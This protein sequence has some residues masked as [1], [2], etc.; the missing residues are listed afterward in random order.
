[1][2]WRIGI[3]AFWLGRLVNRQAV[4]HGCSAACCCADSLILFAFSFVQ[5]E[6]VAVHP[7]SLLRWM[8]ET[9]ESSA[10]RDWLVATAPT[11]FSNMLGKR[12]L[13]L[14][15]LKKF[16]N[17][18]NIFWHLGSV[19]KPEQNDIMSRTRHVSIAFL[20]IHNSLMLASELKGY[21]C[22]LLRAML[23]LLSLQPSK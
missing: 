21:S 14:L 8:S 12:K 6:K 5:W 19:S 4:K 3:V 20:Q 11:C 10:D 16:Y 2:G 23:I 7:P 1:M 17:A 15:V 13:V 18:S 22:L 9:W